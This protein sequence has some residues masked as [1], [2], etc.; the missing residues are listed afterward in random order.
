MSN[1]VRRFAPQCVYAIHLGRKIVVLRCAEK[2]SEFPKG[3][4]AVVL[5]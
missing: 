5:F 2:A 3:G 4:K 1:A